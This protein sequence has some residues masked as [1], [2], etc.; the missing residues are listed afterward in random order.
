M[1]E[2]HQR[3]QDW[4]TAGAEGEPPR[5]AAVHA[6]VCAACRQSIAALDLIAGV[7]PGRARVPAIPARARNSRLVPSARVAGMATAVLFGAVLLGTGASRLISL[8]RGNG[9]IAL[10]SQTPD[11]GILGQ[12]ATAQPSGAGIA[13]SPGESFVAFG[14]PGPSPRTGA[15]QTPRPGSTA[16]PTPKPS[17]T[18]SPGATTGPTGAVTGTPTPTGAPT[19]IPTPTVTQ[20][21]TPTPTPTP[22]PVPT[23]VPTA[24][25][26]ITNLMAIPG[27]NSGE[28]ELSWSTPADGGSQ[29][30][31]YRIYRGT[32]SGGEAFLV[33]ISPATAYVDSSL[34][35]GDVYWYEVT[36][37]N[38]VG[39]GQFS[40]EATTQAP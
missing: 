24:P 38:T 1:N 2:G 8:T 11:Q 3:F 30:T 32:S 33:E 13:P 37:V 17:A 31:S 15:R 16:T 18:S 35:S 23:P 26:S 20:N 25:D 27:L 5:D 12:T 22:T 29:L 9:A 39:E 7:D 21:P 40:N 4:L 10:A 19:P 28:I 14:P 34:V 36:A 6:S